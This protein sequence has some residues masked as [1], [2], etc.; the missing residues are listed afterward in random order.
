MNRDISWLSFNSRVLQ[1]ATDKRVPLLERLKFLGIFSNN[2]DEFFR[3]RVAFYK[4][5]QRLDKSTLRSQKINFDINAV[6]DK[7]NAIVK[8]Q[9]E[10]FEDIYSQI[11]RDLELNSI[12]IVNE[13]QLSKNQKL[14]LKSISSKIFYPRLCL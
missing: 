11:L 10:I 12:F 9:G 5:L 4:R 2:Q 7:I 3:V 14:L 8:D 13:E 6:L 1:E